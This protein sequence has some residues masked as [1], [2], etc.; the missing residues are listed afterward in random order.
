MQSNSCLCDDLGVDRM[1]RILA[2][3]MR[4]YSSTMLASSGIMTWLA[5]LEIAST[6]LL[7]I[8]IDLDLMK[9]NGEDD[10]RFT[11]FALMDTSC[12]ISLS[13]CENA[14]EGGGRRR[15]RK[16]TIY[17]WDWNP[18]VLYV[19][20]FY[21]LVSFHQ[22][23]SNWIYQIHR[24]SIMVNVFMEIEWAWLWWTEPMLLY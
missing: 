14:K 7:K 1:A 21:G 9:Q 16:F 11:V 15:L 2:P 24:R 19:I 23:V 18:R 5:K 4:L 12:Q 22:Y 8:N 3:E 20:S 10:T 13:N 17:C 6:V